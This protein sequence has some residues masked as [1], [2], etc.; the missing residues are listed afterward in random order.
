MNAG[1]I[2]SIEAFSFPISEETDLNLYAYY[3][4][5]IKSSRSYKTYV[6]KRAKEKGLTI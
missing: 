3:Q 4:I 5:E 6:L 1:E 2:L